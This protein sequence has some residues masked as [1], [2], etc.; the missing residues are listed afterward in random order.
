MKTYKSRYEEEKMKNRVLELKYRGRIAELEE[1]E[2]ERSK[3]VDMLIAELKHEQDVSQ[4]NMT[5]YLAAED[6]R[7]ALDRKLK[8]AEWR[9]AKLEHQLEKIKGGADEKPKEK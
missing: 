2:K 4:Q 7:K 6:E 8:E 3:A 1:M 9:I 5:M